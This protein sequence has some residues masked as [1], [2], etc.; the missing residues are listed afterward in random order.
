MPNPLRSD[1]VL[2]NEAFADANA[3]APGMSLGALI[4]GKRRDVTIVGVASSP[5]FVFAVAPGTLLPEPRRFGVL[6]M[7]REALGLG[8]AQVAGGLAGMLVIALQPA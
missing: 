4:Y 3:L 8:A 2:I 7:G 5:E 6:W 1:E